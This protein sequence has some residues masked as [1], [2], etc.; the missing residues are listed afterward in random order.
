MTHKKQAIQNNHTRI[1]KRLTVR[2]LL[3]V[4]PFSFALIR[5]SGRLIHSLMFAS[6]LRFPTTSGGN[7]ALLLW[8]VSWNWWW[9]SCLQQ[10][11]IV[12][13]I[14]RHAELLSFMLQQFIL[15]VVVFTL[16]V[17]YLDNKKNIVSDEVERVKMLYI[18]TKTKTP[19]PIPKH[20]N[21]KHSNATLYC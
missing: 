13:W 9:W 19:T 2:S 7:D 20:N 21:H 11:W 4:F 8:A 17:I 15:A 10:S 5:S 6:S 16:L 14:K 12:W 18:N 3:V 1:H